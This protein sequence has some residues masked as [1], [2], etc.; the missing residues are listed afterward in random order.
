MKKTEQNPLLKTVFELAN[1][2]E[3]ESKDVTINWSRIIELVDEIKKQ[4]ISIEPSETDLRPEE[5]EVECANELYAGAINYC[6][7]YGKFDVRPNG[8]SATKMHKLVQETY[9]LNDAMI[10][11]SPEYAEKLAENLA[12][13]RFPLLEER[14]RHL[15]E[16]AKDGK[17]NG[18]ANGEPFVYL[19]RVYQDDFNYLFTKMI[20]LFPGYASDMFLKKASL[21]FLTLYRRFGWFKK[22]LWQLPV[23]ADYQVPRV[24]NKLGC[25]TYSSELKTDIANHILIPKHSL[26][27]CGIR[28]ATIK[29]CQYL[30]EMTGY[31]IAEIDWWLWSKRK[32]CDGPFHLTITT[33]Y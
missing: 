18:K 10:I 5:C 29:V 23:P 13:A 20:R 25:I 1:K 7:W 8:C 28:A 4:N 11:F 21:Y 9:D 15:L 19:V 2:I 24:L 26:R 27:E 30:V 12:I 16:V 31:N 22:D 32:E 33:D 14:R 6:Y 3:R 17:I